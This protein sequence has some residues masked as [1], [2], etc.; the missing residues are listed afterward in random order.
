[1]DELTGIGKTIEEAIQEGLNRLGASR[2]EVEVAPLETGRRGF[3]G[4]FGRREAKVKVS[5]RPEDRIRVRVL[6]RN[7]LHRLGLDATPEV[8]E[9]HDEIV[10]RL[11]EEASMLIG[12][13][14]Q[15]LDALQYLASRIINDDREKWKKITIDID[16]YRNRRDE[17]LQNLAER[18]AREAVE[19]GRDQ[20]TEPLSAHDRRI[21]HMTLRDHP[22][23]TTF[24][25]GEGGYRR[26]IIAL[27]EGVTQ[28]QDRSRQGRA[29]RGRGSRSANAS[30]RSPRRSRTG[31]RNESNRRSSERSQR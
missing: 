12:H 24:S 9:S 26:V 25:V 17:S 31:Q 5:V 1:M 11:G 18:L 28:R 16:N 22:K 3:L 23:V 7:V 6:I 27:R 14:G 10:I 29:K 2:D 4:L 8:E 21:V 15:T 20:R 13:H 30:A 19:D